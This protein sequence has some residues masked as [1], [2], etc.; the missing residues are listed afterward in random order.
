MLTRFN[1]QCRGMDVENMDTPAS[2]MLFGYLEQNPEC[3]QMFNT[4]ETAG[5]NQVVCV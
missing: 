4:W 1:D 3:P 2:R 5:S